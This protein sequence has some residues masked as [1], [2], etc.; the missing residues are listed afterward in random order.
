[1][2]EE[3]KIEL[4]EDPEAEDNKQIDV[5]NDQETPKKN[6]ENIENK[7]WLA[8]CNCVSCLLSTR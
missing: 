4:I 6:K 8:V 3:E 7:F 1:M 5:Q 2:T